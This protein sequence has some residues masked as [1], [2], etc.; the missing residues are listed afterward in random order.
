MNEAK[1]LVHGYPN[2]SSLLGKY[3]ISALRGSTH[4]HIR[5]QL[6]SLI[7]ASGIRYQLLPKIDSFMKSF[8]FKWDDQTIDIQERSLINHQT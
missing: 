6:L 2:T 1:G 5:G 4:K 8:L 3:N 7:D